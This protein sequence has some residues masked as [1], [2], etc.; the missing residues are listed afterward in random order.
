[1]AESLILAVS[2][3]FGFLIGFG[4]GVR[5][6]SYISKGMSVK[7]LMADKKKKVWLGL[8]GWLFAFTGAYIGYRIGLYFAGYV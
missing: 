6:L 5:A 4:M 1:M 7:E 2:S 3:M 8:F